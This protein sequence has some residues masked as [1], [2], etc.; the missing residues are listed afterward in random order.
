MNALS[1]LGKWS[2]P[3]TDEALESPGEGQVFPTLWL[4]S[5]FYQ[6]AIY[7]DFVEIMAFITVRDLF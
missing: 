2:L 5:G 1:I 4:L 6:S 7:L 3:W